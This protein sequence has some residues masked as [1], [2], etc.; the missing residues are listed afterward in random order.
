M[1]ASARVKLHSAEF[2][3]PERDHWWN[4]DYLELIASRVGFDEVRSVL[5]VGCGIGH[6]GRLLAAV[7]PSDA[8]ILGVDREHEWVARA[9]VIAAERGL[10][11]LTYERGAAEDLHFADDSFDLVTCQ[12]LLIHVPSPRS[13]LEEMLRVTR[14]GGLILAAEPNNRAQLLVA[15]SID[16]EAPIDELLDRMWFALK[17]ER[18]QLA[19]GEGFASVGDLVPGYLAELGAVDVRTFLCD[20]PTM[21]VPPY[22]SEGQQVAR[23]HALREAERNRWVW[24]REDVL[25]YFVAGGGSAEEFDAAWERRLAELQRRAASLREGSFHTAG[26][27]IHYLIAARKPK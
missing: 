22:E 16:A 27:A 12:T 19:L 18:G 15:T 26:G 2:F 7:L 10:A 24:D 25:R 13:V 11:G 9:R 17:C 3:G 23:S 20:K 5:D 4:L 1:A 21:L 6:W 14:P 8:T